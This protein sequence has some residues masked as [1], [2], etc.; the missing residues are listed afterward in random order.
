[1]ISAPSDTAA[2]GWA[3]VPALATAAVIIT[4][5]RPVV[6][7]ILNGFALKNW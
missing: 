5:P 3:G 2:D 1:M 6:A 4:M 7:A